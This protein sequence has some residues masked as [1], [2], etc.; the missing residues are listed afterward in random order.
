ML[1]FDIF[2]PACGEASYRPRPITACQAN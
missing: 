1:L 2:S